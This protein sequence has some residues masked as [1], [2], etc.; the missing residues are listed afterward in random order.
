MPRELPPA[1]REIAEMQC[2][3][4]SRRQAILGG[5][6]PDVID[7]LLRSGRWQLLQRGC[8][9][10]FTGQP[11]REATLWA[12]LHRA[13]PGAALSHQT[14][15]ELFRLTDY[16]SSLI[17]L[18]I[19]AGR[20]V[21][22]IPG[23]VIHRSVRIQDARHPVLLPPRTRIEETV[24]DLVQDAV[25][26]DDAFT[27]ACQACQ[28]GLTT[29]ERIAYAMTRR[30]KLRWRAELSA[31]LTDIGEGAHSLLE[32]RYIRRVERP[33]GL[34]RAKRQLQVIHGTRYSY[35]DNVY[36]DYC[37]SVELDGR[38]AHPDH[39]RW[40]DSRRVNEAAAEGRVTLVYNWADVSWRSC[41]TAWQIALA[42]RQGGWKGT[43]R[44]CGPTCAIPSP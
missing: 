40:L 44:Q 38:V 12:V 27:W 19:P 9:A 26:V 33:H 23:A 10:V 29:A 41:A 42:L 11:S 7:R 28:R 30:K 43:F 36:E 25:T 13:G 21:D 14:A 24:L 8:Y 17:H 1:C 15:A 6:G 3:V 32:Q 20:R 39:R 18:T 34:P 16:P 2:G 22:P 35:R 31:A 5:I 37:V 4:L